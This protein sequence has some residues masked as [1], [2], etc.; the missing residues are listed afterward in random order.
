M[1]RR[2]FAGRRRAAAEQAAGMAVGWSLPLPRRWPASFEALNYRDFRLLWSGALVSNVGTWLQAVAQGW[3]VL[4]LT[5]SALLLGLVSAVGSIPVMTLS[6]FGGVLADQF[7]R[8]RL[9]I[10]AEIGLTVFTLIMA[11]LVT[12]HLITVS[13]LLILVLLVG[14]ASALSGPTWQSFL[15]DLVPDE[16]LL[17]AIALN[18]AQFNVARVLGPAMAGTLIAIIGI[19]GCFT[20]NGLSFVAVIVA[21]LMMHRPLRERVP[22]RLSPWQS[23]VEGVRY[24][25][26]HPQV[27]AIMSLATVHTVFGMPFL[28]LMPVFARDVYHGTAGDLGIFL[29]AM[30]AGA[31]AGAL[32]TAR[33]GA[34]RRKGALILGMEAI[35]ALSLLLF[36][37]M[38]VRVAALPALALV[39]FWMVSFFA[40]A[41]SALQILSEDAVR[42]RV[43]S[44]WT[45]ASWGITPLGSLWAGAAATRLGAPTVVSLGAVICL[46]YTAALALASPRLRRL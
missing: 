12:A 16:V 30:G 44:I 26:H 14:V 32:I 39:G 29:S 23:L 35:F 13:W 20:L 11:A 24:T 2:I 31:V 6:L 38:P 45:I 33:F 42:G 9:L 28:M 5:N 46:L 1:Q 19:A 34:V 22:R 18:S 27:R 41:N 37:H 17:N 40:V 8:R 3:L 15:S 21:L 10:V 4:Q 36:A 43:M 25:I 7:D